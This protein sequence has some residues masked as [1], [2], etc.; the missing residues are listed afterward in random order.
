MPESG[1]LAKETYGDHHFIKRFSY[2]IQ[3]SQNLGSL[4]NLGIYSPQAGKKNSVL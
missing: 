1:N 2:S 3:F 4:E